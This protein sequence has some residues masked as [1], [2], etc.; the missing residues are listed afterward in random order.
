MPRTSIFGHETLKERYERCYERSLALVEMPVRSQMVNTSLGRTHVLIFGE[1]HKPPMILLHGMMMSSTMWY[2]NIRQLAKWRH[3][4]AID[5]I[6]DMG[7]SE[8]RRRLSNKNQAALWLWEVMEALH[9]IKADLAGHSLGG[10]LATNFALKHPRRVSKLLLY[11]PAATFYRLSWRFLANMYP[12]LLFRTEKWI[13]RAF[14][15]FS[16][17]NEPL[18]PPYRD[19]VIA[20]FRY[21]YPRIRIIPSVISK[22]DFQHFQVPTLLLIGEKEVIY[23]AKKALAAAKKKLPH[24]EAHLIQG[25]SHVLTIEHAAEVNE[26]SIRFL[27]R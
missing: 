20:G 6:G 16:S 26:R 15:F 3:I 14:R 9:I 13:D 10:Y 1:A 4:Y 23:P 12:A 27:D 25:A 21:G 17:K 24:I 2:P 19:Q 7:R 8:L 5:I 11:A 22:K 18:L